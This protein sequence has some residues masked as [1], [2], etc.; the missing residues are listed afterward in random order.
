MA[1]VF[2]EVDGD[3]LCDRLLAAGLPIGPVRDMAEVMNHPHT[4]H[5]KMRVKQDWYEM[6][7]IPI[8]F[9]RTPGS[10]RRLPPKFAEHAREILKEHGFSDDDIAALAADGALV[11][12]RRKG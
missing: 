10:I 4:A 12:E 2:S 7:G 6:A 9:S 3:A 1:A 11:E 8:K 5:R